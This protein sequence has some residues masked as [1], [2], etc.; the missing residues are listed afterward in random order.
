MLSTGQTTLLLGVIAV[1]SIPFL[2]SFSENTVLMVGELFRAISVFCS[3]LLAE[4]PR[5]IFGVLF[6]GLAICIRVRLFALAHTCWTTLGTWWATLGTWWTIVH[7]TVF[8]APTFGMWILTTCL[9]TVL[10]GD[11]IRVGIYHFVNWVFMHIAMSRSRTVFIIKFTMGILLLLFLFYVHTIIG[12][13]FE[14]K[15]NKACTCPA[16]VWIPTIRQCFFK[17]FDVKCQTLNEL[18]AVFQPYR[19]FYNLWHPTTKI[20]ETCTK[21]YY[22]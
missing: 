11:F 19:F 5:L 20:W 7:V 17:T 4:W 8:P 21:I 6:F 12:H 13:N 15:R 9:S 3:P 22:L 18:V 14:L 10:S 16:D 1:L 2:K